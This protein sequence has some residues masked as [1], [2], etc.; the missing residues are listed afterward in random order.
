MDILLIYPHASTSSIEEGI[1]VPPL[2]LAYLAATLEAKGYQ[3]NILD[4]NAQPKLA[5]HF[6]D[7][8]QE[9]QPKIVG[10]T[11]LTPFYSTVLNLARTVKESINATVVI[12]G[13]HATALPEEM[14]N[15]N[16]IDYVVIGEGEAIMTELA[17]SLL[18]GKGKPEDIKGIAYLKDGKPCRNSPH[19]YIK[20]LDELPFPARH[21][22]PIE[23]YQSPQYQKSRVTSI[24]TSRG[25]PYS[26]IFCDYRFLMGP[27][28]RRRS[29]PNVADEI[30][31]CVQKYN[32]NHISFRDS[33]FTFDETWISQLCTLIK[34]R[35]LK[36]DWDCNG[37]VNLVTMR[38]LDEMR[39][40]G[41]NLI[42]YGIESG[43]Q[44]ILDFA[45]KNLTTE[46]SLNA[47]KMTKKAGIETLSYF[48]IGLPGE[49]WETIKSTIAFAAKLD[50]DYTQFSLA[51]PFP[52]TPL[53][54]YAR[55]Q[56]LIRPG[57][58]WDDF[59]PINK[60]IM[61]TEALNF[62]GLEKALKRAYKSYYLRPKYIIK[63]ALK[64]RPGNI[65]QNFNGLKMF[66]QQQAHS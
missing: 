25:C 9:Q 45:H 54:D 3:V 42:S 57:V 64:L 39:E 48:I 29:P 58:S 35:N 65:K 20:N 52:G 18:H 61:R 41:C 50:S 55:E 38:M 33:T 47:L 5:S 44:A 60:A 31:E 19:D 10:M 7:I 34:Q 17:D 26:C 63:R 12:G 32:I 37:R 14:L 11:C 59:S 53:Y 22:L 28:F 40:A 1:K 13:A 66:V 56:H 30:A 15:G 2:G 36:V 49:N 21:L 23:R 24:V 46:Q 27:K 51:T 43:D 4:M 16:N 62:E 8:L 6:K